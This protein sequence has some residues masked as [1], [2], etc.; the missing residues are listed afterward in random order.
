MYESG[1]VLHACGPELARPFAGVTFSKGNVEPGQDEDAQ[2][3][4][5]R[6]VQGS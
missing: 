4:L 2:V 5:K 6:G 3:Y 1:Q